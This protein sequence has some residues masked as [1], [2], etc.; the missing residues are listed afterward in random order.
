[1]KTSNL[2]K[3]IK[4]QMKKLKEGMSP[5][6][7]ADAKEAERLANHPEREKIMKIKQMMD[8]EKGIT[9]MEDS[10]DDKE[11]AEYDKGWYGESLKETATD[12]ERTLCKN[13]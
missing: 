3:L 6:E 9:G 4:E 5:E 11:Q 8:K 7:W 12:S 1:M 2:R 10:E 13:F